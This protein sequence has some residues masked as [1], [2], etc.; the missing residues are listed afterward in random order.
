MTSKVG[1]GC[2]RRHPVPCLH[3]LALHSTSLAQHHR[4]HLP[5]PAAACG[6]D[7]RK[8]STGDDERDI[9]NAETTATMSMMTASSRAKTSP[10]RFCRAKIGRHDRRREWQQRRRRRRLPRR[11]N[12]QSR[13]SFPPSCRRCPLLVIALSTAAAESGET[14]HPRLK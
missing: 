14:D 5:L 8:G 9:A 13:C 6:V 12:H 2:R 10:K 1:R 4:C 11:G 3:C 7:G